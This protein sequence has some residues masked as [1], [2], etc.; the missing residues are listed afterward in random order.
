[1]VSEVY[2]FDVFSVHYATDLDYT[3]HI[4]RQAQYIMNWR[5]DLPCVY[6]LM[7]IFYVLVEHI[8]I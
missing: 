4:Q 5:G 6:V 3:I 7:C 2:M 8:Y 1:M